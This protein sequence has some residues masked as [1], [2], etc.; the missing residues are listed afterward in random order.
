MLAL[1]KSVSDVFAII[2]NLI[3]SVNFVLKIK[4]TVV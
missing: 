1:S 4:L 2:R 3:C